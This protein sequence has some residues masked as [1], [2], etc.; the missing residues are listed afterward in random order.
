MPKHGRL[1]TSYI[2]L[3][4][5]KRYED[6]TYLVGLVSWGSNECDGGQSDLVDMYTDTRQ[7]M[8]FIG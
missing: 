3:L 5:F 7:Y 4:L 1:Y 6:K 8:H 2:F